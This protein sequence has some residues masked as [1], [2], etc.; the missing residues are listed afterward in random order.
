MVDVDSGQEK[1]LNIALNKVEGG[2]D[3]EALARLPAELKAG[4]ADI[5]LSGFDIEEIDS[6]KND[7]GMDNVIEIDPPVTEDDFDVQ[8]ALDKI[9]EPETRRGDVG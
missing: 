3:D 8:R 1:L 9:Q 7:F 4:G 5:T 2:W 6:L